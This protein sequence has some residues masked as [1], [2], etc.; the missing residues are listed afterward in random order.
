MGEC[1]V[2]DRPASSGGGMTRGGASGFWLPVATATAFVV[3]WAFNPPDIPLLQ[4]DSSSY[5]D[6]SSIRGR[7]YYALIGAVGDPARMIPVQLISYFAAAAFVGRELARMTGTVVAGV[8]YV[9]F[10][11]A[12]RAVVE[13][14]FTVM[15]E[16][17]AMATGMIACIVL[18]RFLARPGLVG[19]L[20][21]AI[22]GG[23]LVDLRP[24]MI[25][26]GLVLLVLSPFAIAR[27]RA[28]FLAACAMLM[29]PAIE[30]ATRDPASSEA[31]RSFLALNLSGKYALLGETQAPPLARDLSDTA[32][33]MRARIDAIDSPLVAYE[34]RINYAEHLRYRIW[35]ELVARHGVGPQDQLGAA[36][37]PL[38]EHPAAALKQIA[39]D[40][41]AFWVRPDIL[42]AE[43]GQARARIIE[44][45]APSRLRESEPSFPGTRSGRTWIARLCLLTGFLISLAAFAAMPFRSNVFA[46]ALPFAFGSA[47]FIWGTYGM[48]AILHGVIPRYAFASWP[49]LGALLAMASGL[50][51]VRIKALWR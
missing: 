47:A 24:A 31:R 21:L 51:F 15:P 19:A 36:L 18:A 34:L 9:A 29:W 16:A 13:S 41:T 7:V 39:R 20:A 33:E 1:W 17:M 50:A 2:V 42:T 30:A 14:C 37:A 32:A 35:P 28:V 43:E 10:A 11:G 8:I 26:F 48:Y 45:L 22:L 40:L 38:R 49:Q 23:V 44:A 25:G 5:I 12:V 4:P 3:Y 27:R 6:G 46:E